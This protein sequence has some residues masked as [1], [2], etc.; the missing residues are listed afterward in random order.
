MF[1]FSQK[2]SSK[3]PCKSDRR[4]QGRDLDSKW[5]RREGDGQPSTTKR[6]F[7][8]RNTKLQEEEAGIDHVGKGWL[9]EPSCVYEQQKT[10]GGSG[11][12]WNHHNPSSSATQFLPFWR[13]FNCILEFYFKTGGWVVRERITGEINQQWIISWALS[14]SEFIFLASQC[15]R[16]WLQDLAVEDEIQL[17]LEDQVSNDSEEKYLFLLRVPPSPLTTHSSKLYIENVA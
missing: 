8:L 16:F 13:E 7:S 3:S 6:P 15:P 9:K 11:S 10:A 14:K 2:Q 4:G 12:S 5:K 17:C 1:S